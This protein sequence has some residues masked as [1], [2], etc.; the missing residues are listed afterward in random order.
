[1]QEESDRLG[2]KRAD[3]VRSAMGHLWVGYTE[4]AWGNDEAR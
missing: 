1:M 2:R 3:A 4:H